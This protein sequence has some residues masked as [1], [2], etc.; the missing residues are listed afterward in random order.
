MGRGGFVPGWTLNRTV[1]L[2]G[3]FP[4]FSFLLLF[5]LVAL[6]DGPRPGVVLSNPTP[7]ITTGSHVALSSR[8]VC[9][10]LSR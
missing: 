6:H 8:L 7:L 2:I 9:V 5:V 3:G 4:A 10:R 1:R